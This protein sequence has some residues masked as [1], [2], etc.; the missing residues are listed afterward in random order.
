[1]TKWCAAVVS[2]GL[3]VGHTTAAEAPMVLVPGSAFVMGGSQADR[4]QLLAFG[5][6]S[7]GWLERITRLAE[8]GGPQR[9][10]DVADF[11]IDS[12]EVTNRSYLE[13][14]VRTGYRP[15]PLWRT[16]PHLSSPEQPVVGVS[17]FDA[18]AF[19]ESV[20]KRLPSEIEWEKAARGVDARTYSWGDQW[21]RTKLHAADFIADRELERYTDWASWRESSSTEPASR[22]T[23]LV[24]EHPEGASPYGAQD[25]LGNVWEW[26][27]TW[28]DEDHTQKVLRG[29][30]WDVPRLV[31]STWFR[32]NF[33]PP[34][35]L[36]STV[37]GFRCARDA[38]D[39]MASGP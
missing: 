20:D 17:W 14:V 13:F 34:G 9:N 24:G 22:R 35:A 37:T 28:Y 12:F 26:V 18:K 7:G 6:P 16:H 2:L 36:G 8:A 25:M 23:A 19:C 10:V 5:W 21:D 32:E 31:A 3:L 11:F 33:L 27:D 1:M 38:A 39:Q 15:A 4:S 29:G 30:G